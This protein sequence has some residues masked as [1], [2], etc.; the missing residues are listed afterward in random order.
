MDA[1][2]REFAR[3]DDVAYEGWVQQHGGYVLV[4]RKSDDFMLHESSCGHLEL[5]PEFALTSRPRR[6]A[7]SREPL[8]DW[9]KQA[10]GDRPSLCQSC[11]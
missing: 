9:A 8:I 4:Q 7:N 10:T 1:D 3:G 11:M 6:W 2:I 5:T